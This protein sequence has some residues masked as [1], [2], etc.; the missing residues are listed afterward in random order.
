MP[1]IL[2]TFRVPLQPKISQETGRLRQQFI[3]TLLPC[4][5]QGS[6]S[7]RGADT[8]IP[9]T[10]IPGANREFVDQMLLAPEPEPS[11]R[12]KVTGIRKNQWVWEGL[13]DTRGLYKI[14]EECIADCYREGMHALTPKLGELKAS[15][16]VY[17]AC[18]YGCTNT[19]PS[20]RLAPATGSSSRPSTLLRHNF[21]FHQFQERGLLGARLLYEQRSQGTLRT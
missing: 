9:E 8:E 3:T 5:F 12:G 13:G 7:Q 1:E 19:P 15:Y 2:P 14:D 20:L 18:R 4:L 10:L 6:R 21:R 17:R 16:E 11:Y